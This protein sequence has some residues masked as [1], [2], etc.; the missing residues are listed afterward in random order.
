MR[1][2]RR[3]LFNRSGADRR[4]TDRL[5]DRARRPR[6][7]RRAFDRGHRALGRNAQARDRTWPRRP[8][9]GNQCGG[10]RRRRSGHRLH[11]GRRLRRG[12]QGDR[13]ASRGRRDRVRRRLGQGRDR[14]RHGCASA[15]RPC[16]SCRRIRSPAPNIPGPTPALPNCSSN[17]W[18]I[19]TPPDGADATAVDKLA[20]FWRA[21]RRQCRNHG[22]RS[23]RSGARHHQPSAASDRLYDRRHRRRARRR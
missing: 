3:P 18:C 11:S 14:S 6:A 13:P 19:L 21:A 10:G 16:I 5:L 23:S 4:R 17:R 15:R 12:R 7:R 22:G 1:K 8:G 9:G 20:A 2:N